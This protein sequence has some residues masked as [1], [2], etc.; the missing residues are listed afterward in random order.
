VISFV[1]GRL[2]DEC[3]LMIS[4]RRLAAWVGEGRAVTP[5]GVLRPGDVSAAAAAMRVDVPARVRTAAD[6]EVIHR[7]WVAAQ[8]VGLLKVT[9]GRAVA[10][11]ASGGDLLQWW[12]SAVT[13]VLRAESNDDRRR[14]AAV[15]CRMLLGLLAADQPPAAGELEEAVHGLL[16][17]QADY[18]EA[19]AVYQAFRRGVMPVD[20]GMELLGQVGAVDGKGRIT[21]LG[22]WMRERLVAEAP[23]PVTPDLSAVDLLARLVRLPDDEVWR[24]AGRW[25]SGREVAN[26]ADELLAAA[27]D[28][29]PAHRVAAVEVVAGLGEPAIAAWRAALDHPLLRP[30]ARSVLAE[31]EEGPE[32][33]DADRWWLAVEYALAALATD[34]LEEAYH[35]LRE[36]DALHAVADSDH[37]DAEVLT[38]ALADL[39]AAGG[40]AVPVYQLKIVLSRVRP[41]VWRRVR[42][43]A[44]TTLDALHEVIQVVFDWDDDHLHVF[45]VDGRRYADPYAQLDDCADE[46]RVRLG[47]V[48]RRAGD[49]MR[50]V[51][52]LGDWWEHEI[53]LERIIEPVEGSG[54]PVCVGGQ[55]DAP[56]EHWFPDCGRDPT[57]FNLHMINRGLVRCRPDEHEF[58]RL[59]RADSDDRHHQP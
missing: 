12:W 21:S 22:A 9:A 32:P 13:A 28:A 39:V 17:K 41:A 7:P 38:S 48:L 26:A 2:A 50:Y 3:Q 4:A 52:D 20:A 19:D 49:A 34:G 11:P 16:L 58:E 14:G 36:A 25:L 57:P 31:L 47:K 33:G 45:T 37:P 46:S 56:V 42:L 29:T 44:T 40:P 8:A 18:G 10:V 53:T 59:T 23:P 43:P 1:L 35:L 15:L 6:V 30:H 55:G 51:Y 5:K 54:E 24:Q 27:V